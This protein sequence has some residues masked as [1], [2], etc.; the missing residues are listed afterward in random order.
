MALTLISKDELAAR[1]ALTVLL[2]YKEA[3]A[4]LYKTYPK[5]QAIEQEQ[6]RRD[7]MI[8]KYGTLTPTKAQMQAVAAKEK[9]AKTEKGTGVE[10][11]AG[12]SA[13][14]AKPKKSHKKG[15]GK[16][17][18]AA[19]EAQEAAEAAALAEAMPAPPEG[20]QEAVQGLPDGSMEVSEEVQDAQPEP[21]AEPV[22]IG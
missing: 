13:G 18:Q 3:I 12:T 1:G 7:T 9:A 22:A 10:A 15:A 2:E 11:I 14:A 16:A 5:L 6:K 17:A 19:K 21:V 20:S 8:R 4:E